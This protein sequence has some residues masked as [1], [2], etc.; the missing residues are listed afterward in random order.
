MKFVDE[1]F[2]TVQSGNG[3]RGC[4]SFRRERCIE[5]GGPDGGDGGDGGDVILKASSRTRTLYP[6]RYQK[7]YKAKNGGP[8]EG[9]N[10]HGK[11][12]AP[13][14]IEIPCGTIVSNADTGEIVKD[15]VHGDDT[16][17]IARGGQG[18]RGNKSFTTSTH[19]APK[20]AQP[21]E[22]GEESTLKLELKLIAD[23]GLVG[24]PN[25]GKSTLISVISAAKPK[26]ADYP[27]TTLIPNIGMVDA[28][29]GEPFA[30]AD[31]PGLIEGAHE[32]IGLGIQFLRH[33]ERTG[34]LVHVIDVSQIDSENP[35]AQYDTINREL[36]RYS[37]D[38][39]HKPQIVVLNKMDLP[40]ADERSASFIRAYGN[41]DNVYLVSAATTQGIDRL[42][43]RL[44]EAVYHHHEH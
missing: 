11:N 14:I 43:N 37:E 4:V 30:V 22:P 8:G 10:K 24:L 25:A 42:K 38:L 21:G 13:V 6:F 1:A 17:V 33:I 19:R 5:R 34:V 18:G 26:I 28:G 12:G 16:V 32:G 40:N 3:G 31:I 36:C 39:A 2:I 15:F 41:S 9:K 20:F 27:F 23:V 29:W 35:L 7:L 44:A